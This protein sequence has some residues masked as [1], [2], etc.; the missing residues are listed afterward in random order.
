MAVIVL[1]IANEVT[2]ARHDQQK[3]D[4]GG[5]GLGLFRSKYESLE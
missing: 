1:T 3:C 5:G 4:P 2:Q